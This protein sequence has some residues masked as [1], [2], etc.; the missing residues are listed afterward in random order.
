MTDYNFVTIKTDGTKRAKP[1]TLPQSLDELS[2]VDLT[3]L[4]DEDII[5]FNSSSGNF[6]AVP[7]D[8]KIV[9]TI[10]ER[11]TYTKVGTLVFVRDDDTVYMLTATGWE[12]VGGSVSTGTTV[13][14]T[15]NIGQPTEA[16]QPNT[17][18]RK[19]IPYDITLSE[20][21]IYTPDQFNTK[22]DI[23]I[24]V[25]VGNTYATATSIAGTEKPTLSSDDSNEDTALSSWTT[26]LSKGSFLWIDVESV[27]GL[28][29]VSLELIG[30]KS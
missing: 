15:F 6:E 5:Q 14:M 25:K 16:I 8:Y 30:V 27:S 19:V 13:G 28:N 2:D 29:E 9:Q 7:I 4:S 26:S 17:R 10:A 24:D 18:R 23:V 22:G 1:L 11:D 21:R 12:Q 20:W 3:G